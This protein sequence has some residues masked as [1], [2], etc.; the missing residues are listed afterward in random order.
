MKRNHIRYCLLVT[1][2]WFLPILN[3]LAQPTVLEVSGDITENTTWTDD[4]IKVV[5]D[6]TVM[7]NITLTINPGTYVEFQGYFRIGVNGY[8]KAEGLPGDTIVF[9]VN[10]TIGATDPEVTTGKF[11]GIEFFWGNLN[12]TSII[13]MSHLSYSHRGIII[14][15]TQNVIISKCHIEKNY[16]GMGTIAA[17]YPDCNVIIQ[18]CLIENNVTVAYGGGIRIRQTLNVEITNNIIRNNHAGSNGGGIYWDDVIGG[19]ISGNIIKNNTAKT[20]AG[21]YCYG[22]G[23]EIIE[24]DIIGNESLNPSYGMGGIMCQNVYNCKIINNSIIN[25]KGATIGGIY[26][27]TSKLERSCPISS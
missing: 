18:D 14:S 6:V 22:E 5:G 13:S 2:L 21:I 24:N 15:G 9:T 17:L 27:H 25:N 12:D 4:T 3:T 20:A 8:L 1:L 23:F 10:D 11:K 16:S 19:S 7:N 26:C